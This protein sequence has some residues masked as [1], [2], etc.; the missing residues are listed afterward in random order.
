MTAETEKHELPNNLIM[1]ALEKIDKL[2][3]SN[4]ALSLSIAKLDAV[5]SSMQVNWE[6]LK[7]EVSATRHN[8]QSNFFGLQLRVDVLEGEQEKRLIVEAERTKIAERNSK[9]LTKMYAAVMVIAGILGAF[10]VPWKSIL[11]GIASI[12]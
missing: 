4:T 3:D 2:A 8:A 10:H 1:M 5:I 6:G 7:E 11:Q 12:L 9:R